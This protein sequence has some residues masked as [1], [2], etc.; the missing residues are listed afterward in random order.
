MPIIQ[1]PRLILVAHLLFLCFPEPNAGA[2]ERAAFPPI[3]LANISK[4]KATQI[5]EPIKIDG[6]LDEPSWAKANRSESFVDLIT[7]SPTHLKTHVSVL[8]DQTHLYLGYQI[9]E[10]NLT[11]K[12]KK[13]DDPIY[14]DNDVEF[15][16]AGQ[17]GYYEFEINAHGTIY[18][19]LFVWQS[20]YETSG[21][22]KWPQF[23]RTQPN[24][25]SQAFN[26][27]GYTKHPRGLRWAF[28]EWDFSSIQ[29]AVHIDGTLNDPSDT[30]QGWS[31]EVAI[32]WKELAMLDLSKP[33][34][35][36][37]KV[38]DVWRIDFSRFNQTKDSANPKD[39]GG[40]ALS[41]HGVW[42]SH[43]PEVFP[44]V[45]LAGPGR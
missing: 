27:V 25:Q 40:W 32:P 19:G 10:P 33:R 20:A 17:D 8:W 6:K 41:P 39:S 16:I 7:G 37:P 22:A 23:D 13:E 26:G 1:T 15:F 45:T 21:L 29:S 42:D 2:Q 30:D 4:I 44:Y 36:P 9:E 11:A 5:S 24:V 3:D 18:D 28:L 35:L 34:D 31:V 38:G 43:I 12:F 14:Q